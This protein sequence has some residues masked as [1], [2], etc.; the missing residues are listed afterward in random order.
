MSKIVN[1]CG[2]SYVLGESRYGHTEASG[3]RDVIRTRNIPDMPELWGW[4]D[5]YATKDAYGLGEAAGASCLRKAG[6][7]GTEVDLTIFA[8]SYFPHND[9]T[10]YQGTG[11]ILKE[12]ELNRSLVEGQTLAG[13]A[14]LL[15]AVKNAAHLVQAGVHEN[16]LVVG[17]DALPAGVD[18]FWD[19]GLFS[20]AAAAC[21]VTSS[22]RDG[23][24]QLLGSARGAELDEIIGGVRFNAKKS[25]ADRVLRE[26]V[27][28]SD[29]EL[30]RIAKVFDNNVFLPI[31]S[32]KAASLGF[33]KG[34]LY[35]ENV[36]RVGHC[37]ACD[38]FIN[39]ADFLESRVSSAP[40]R[41]VLQADGNGCCT[42]MLVERAASRL[43]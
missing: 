37:L 23:G 35:L 12:L 31:K 16:V 6:V 2:I 25:L 19:Y 24:L 32:Q 8:C 22:Q 40:E 18:R 9:D 11:R 38:T 1:V 28:T 34:Q 3:F 13:C 29:C 43:H 4:G 27:A 42:A 5:Y 26:L 33:K 21:I 36:S 30:P 17:V 14:S 15:S 7:G 41:F 10:L 20:D 39:L